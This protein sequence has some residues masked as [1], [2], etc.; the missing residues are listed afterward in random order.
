MPVRSVFCRARAVRSCCSYRSISDTKYIIPQPCMA[1]NQCCCNQSSFFVVTFLPFEDRKGLQSVYIYIYIYTRVLRLRPP[2]QCSSGARDLGINII[3]AAGGHWNDAWLLRYQR[4]YFCCFTTDRKMYNALSE[5][6]IK[7]NSN[8]Q[9]NIHPPG[10]SHIFALLL[11]YYVTLTTDNTN[12]KRQQ[13]I[14]SVTT[15]GIVMGGVP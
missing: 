4:V 12:S 8:N 10:V 9:L 14:I 6:K 7:T 1:A 2:A 11:V 3:V 15:Y 13:N 5:G